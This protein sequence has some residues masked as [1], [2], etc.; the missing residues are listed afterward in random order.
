MEWVFFSEGEVVMKGAV[1]R[2]LIDD[3]GCKSQM[4]VRVRVTVGK[5]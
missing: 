2:C 3:Y 5:S 4:F 1:L